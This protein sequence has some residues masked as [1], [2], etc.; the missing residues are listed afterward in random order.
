MGEIKVSSVFRFLN[1]NG[2]INL[3]S[4]AVLPSPIS[5]DWQP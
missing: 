3:L 2:L 5:H 4:S 1:L